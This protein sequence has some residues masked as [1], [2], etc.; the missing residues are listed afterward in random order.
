M[1]KSAKRLAFA[2][3]MGAL[4]VVGKFAFSFIPN[5]E[6]VTTL[7]IAYCFVFGFDGVISS[8]VFCT[9]DVIIYPPSIDV[10]ISYY[11]Y[12][13]LMAITIATLSKLKV[14]NFIPHFVTACVYTLLFGAI[15]SLFNSLFFGV[16]FGA[17][18]VAGLYFY[19]IHLVSTAVFMI[20]GF[21]PV[22]KVLE[23]VKKSANV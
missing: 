20:I 13:N 2:G 16:P 17:V 21:K 7:L 23:R 9:L 12:W 18:Y 11:I 6:V 1:L 5:V 14:K 8:L 3:V 15:T 10:V 4:L 22:T 19:A